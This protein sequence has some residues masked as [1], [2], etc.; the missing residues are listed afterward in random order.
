MVSFLNSWRIRCLFA[1]AISFSVLNSGCL[2]YRLGS[3][4]PS[5]IKTIAIQ[6]FGNR[7]GEPLAEHELTKTTIREFQKDGTLKIARPEEADLVLQCTL[8]KI[9]LDPLRYDRDDR[10]KPNEYR[11]RITVAYA[12]KQ[13]GTFDTIEEGEV[14]GDSTFVFTGNLTLAKKNALPRAAEDMAER[15]VQKVVEVW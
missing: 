13:G 3:T 8:T 15:L 12:L 1:L 7:S 10:S 11:L 5:N 2:G 4:L 6:A 14:I 9:D